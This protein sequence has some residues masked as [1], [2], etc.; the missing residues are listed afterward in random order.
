MLF[1]ETPIASQG[2][3][4]TASPSWEDLEQRFDEWKLGIQEDFVG[5]TWENLEPNVQSMLAEER[6]HYI[7]AMEAQG[8]AYQEYM[9]ARM[10]EEEEKR[11]ENIKRLGVYGGAALLAYLL[12][13]KP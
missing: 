7:T 12:L 8:Q 13:K 1:G 3:G 11:R 2:I 6:E 5:Q 10:A 4:E 9:D